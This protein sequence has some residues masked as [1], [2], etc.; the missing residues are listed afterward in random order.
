M[1]LFAFMLLLF[2][3]AVA[4]G[5]PDEQLTVRMQQRIFTLSKDSTGKW[6][7]PTYMRNDLIRASDDSVQIILFP[8]LDTM[9]KLIIKKDD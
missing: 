8:V 7:V 2:S 1:K 6:V 4:N 5:Q 9:I 3:V